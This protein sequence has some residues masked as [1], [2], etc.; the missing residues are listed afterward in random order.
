MLQIFPVLLAGGTGTSLWPL[1]RKSYPKQFSNLI[2]GKT[3][4]QSS[5]LRLSS[6]PSLLRTL[7][8]RILTTGSSLENSYKKL[9]LILA[10]F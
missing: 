1:S 7:P 4:F 3:L 8:L 6:G 2:N 10:Q 9:V 5:A